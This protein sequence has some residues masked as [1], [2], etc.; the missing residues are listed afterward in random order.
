M[1]NGHTHDSLGRGPPRRIYDKRSAALGMRVIIKG[2]H[3]EGMLQMANAVVHRVLLA[4]RH[5]ADQRL[6]RLIDD[7]SG[8]QMDFGG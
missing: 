4:N 2:L 3:A 8:M 1:A 7:V 6:Q 5:G